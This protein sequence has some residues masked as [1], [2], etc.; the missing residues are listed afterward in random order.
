MTA[1]IRTEA[2]RWEEFARHS[3]A[4]AGGMLSRTAHGTV[5]ARASRVQQ[6]SL[7]TLLC[8]PIEAISEAFGLVCTI[9]GEVRGSCA[10]LLS[11]SA[12][13]ELAAILLFQGGAGAPRDLPR[14]HLLALR[15][16]ALAET[17]NIM[18]SAFL[19]ALSDKLN[20]L[21]VSG[22]PQ[23]ASDTY[24][25][26]VDVM[27]LAAAQ[28]AMQ[29]LVMKTVLMRERLNTEVTLLFVPDP[30]SLTRLKERLQGSLLRQHRPNTSS[31]L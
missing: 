4:L 9:E 21:T 28:D 22:A 7:R 5:V 23:F 29:V 8:D 20:F 18:I 16:S 10:L 31:I 26:I 27:V 2:R 30:L 19:K 1:T 13:E 3:S 17:A 24:G 6:K 11:S 15:Q 25:S 12:A 14:H